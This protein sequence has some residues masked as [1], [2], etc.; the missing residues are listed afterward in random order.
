[1]LWCGHSAVSGLIAWRDACCDLEFF[2][3]MGRLGCAPWHLAVAGMSLCSDCVSHVVSSGTR[4][5]FL[6]LF[7]GLN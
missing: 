5:E 7:G 4:S 1:M 2:M 6:I 3:G